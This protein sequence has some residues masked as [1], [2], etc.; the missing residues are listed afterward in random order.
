MPKIHIQENGIIDFSTNGSSKE[1]DKP[2]NDYHAI[3][4]EEQLQ[5][6]KS[7]LRNEKYINI[8]QNKRS[9]EQWFK[10]HAQIL[11]GVVGCVIFTSFYTLIPV[12]NLFKYPYF[13][14]ELPLQIIIALLPNWAAMVIFRCSEYKVHSDN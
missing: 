8:I 10:P 4:A 1:V 3:L 6:N 14:Y 5:I 2:N 7:K 9:H 11:V 13:W 12:H